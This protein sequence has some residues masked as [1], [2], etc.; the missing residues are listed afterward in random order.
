MHSISVE[1]SI[2]LEMSSCNLLL[3][4]VLKGILFIC[5][6]TQTIIQIVVKTCCK[7]SIST[8]TNQFQVSIVQLMNRQWKKS[9]QK[10]AKRLLIFS[11]ECCV[12][13]FENNDMKKLIANNKL[14]LL[15]SLMHKESTIGAPEPDCCVHEVRLSICS[16][17]SFLVHVSLN[18]TVA[19]Q[20]LK[21]QEE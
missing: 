4:K 7:T 12:P 8:N 3:W 14:L 2:Y 18:K 19:K 13:W 20:V 6:T 16:M 17:V 5:Y 9:N 21:R 15:W 11:N 10:I 1:W